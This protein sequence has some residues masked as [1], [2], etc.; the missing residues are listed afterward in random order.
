MPVK[1]DEAAVDTHTVCPSDR[2]EDFTPTFPD[3]E[4]SKDRI[5]WAR[6]SGLSIANF[7]KEKREGNA[8]VQPEASL[9]FNDHIKITGDPEMIK[10][11][12]GSNAFRDGRVKRVDTLEEAYVLTAQ[13]RKL[14]QIREIESSVDE[15]SPTVGR[16]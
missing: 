9:K 15:K 7:V 1:K 11:I 13:V 4:E 5:Y 14:R 6:A 12:E 3:K 8:I 16:R 10:F 2:K